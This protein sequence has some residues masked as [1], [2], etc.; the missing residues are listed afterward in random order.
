MRREGASRAPSNAV[1]CRAL[2]ELPKKKRTKKEKRI[3]RAKNQ[4]GKD[5]NHWLGW[6]RVRMLFTGWE[7]VLC[8]VF[9]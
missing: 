1:S 2:A 9:G 7:W 8:F 6:I 3:K 5:Q 4:M